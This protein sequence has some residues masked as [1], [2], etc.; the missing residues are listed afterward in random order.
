MTLK[1]AIVGAGHFAYRVHIPV[2]A[3]RPEVI[4][5]S[6]CRIG[7]AELHL[8]KDE[9]G[10]EFA[11][12]NWREILKRDVDIVVVAS[13]HRFHFEQAL[14]FL[15]KGCHVL[16]EKPLCLRAEEAWNL[17][18]EARRRS[19]SLLVSHGWNYKP[20][21]SNARDMVAHIGKIEHVLVHMASFTREVF[22][23]QGGVDQWSHIAI[24][25]QRKTWQDPDGG[26]GFAYGQL[27]HALGILYWLTDLRAETV[28]AVTWA[29]SND[30]DL[31]DSAIVR[32]TNG[33]TG[34][35]S[36]TCGIPNGHGF[37]VDIRIYG[38]HGAV[39]LDLER[40][41]LVLKLPG[42]EI[43]AYDVS[44]GQWAYDCEGP[45]NALVDLALGRGVNQSCGDV[46]ARSVETLY[47]L[48]T[49]A[50]SD[51][52]DVKINLSLNEAKDTI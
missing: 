42:G 6:V 45:P 30:I 11:T 29:N 4:L 51:G 46:G 18:K 12:E 22:N 39:S 28:K 41:R 25:P 14:A 50:Q 23:G 16:V 2:L 7:E 19:V 35:L 20:G 8:I 47:A 52:D 10:F 21:L 3:S 24:Q 32:F 5:D 13:P 37:E 17:E 33:A 27:S 38:E 36:G 43:K 1:A 15:K 44:P 49:S 40:E 31:H 9:F 26:G 48:A 34:S